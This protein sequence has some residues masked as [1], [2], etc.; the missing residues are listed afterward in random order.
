MLGK[1]TGSSQFSPLS[2][3]ITCIGIFID[4]FIDSFCLLECYHFTV[5]LTT[6][7][8]HQICNK[9]GG[10][11]MPVIIRLG[12]YRNKFSQNAKLSKSKFFQIKLMFIFVTLI[13]LFYNITLKDKTLPTLLTTSMHLCMFE[14]MY[15][16]HFLQGM[17]FVPDFGWR[18]HLALVVLWRH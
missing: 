9:A 10:S 16:L 11:Q 13:L 17:L 14:S 3:V 4:I 1:Q 15:L 18:H 5:N 6:F 12:I 8:K 7:K 2:K